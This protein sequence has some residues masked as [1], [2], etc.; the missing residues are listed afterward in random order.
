M[1]CD[2][3]QEGFTVPLEIKFLL[4][5][6]VD[7]LHQLRI[8]ED[9]LKQPISQILLELGDSPILVEFLDQLIWDFSRGILVPQRLFIALQ[10][11]LVLLVFV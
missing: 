4:E 5:L 1:I 7:A 10:G 2:G 9:H 6:L 3:W 11:F 8:S